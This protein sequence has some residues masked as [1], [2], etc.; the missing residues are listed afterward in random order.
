MVTRL[1][2]LEASEVVVWVAACLKRVKDLGCK[3]F[4]FA[5][6]ISYPTLI[7]K[8]DWYNNCQILINFNA[9]WNDC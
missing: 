7:L 3:I 5:L 1:L 4:T 9:E 6:K 2:L 8:L